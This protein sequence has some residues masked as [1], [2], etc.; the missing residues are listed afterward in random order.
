MTATKLPTVATVD[1][2]L[3]VSTTSKITSRKWKKNTNTLP[4]MDPA[5][6]SLPLQSKIFP[7]LTSQPT[8]L[9]NSRLPSQSNQSQL[10]SKPTHQFSKDTPVVFSTPPL[11]EPA[12]ITP[13]LLLVMEPKKDKITTSSETPG[14]P[15][16][17]SLVTSEW[18]LLKVPVSAVSKRSPST[19]PPTE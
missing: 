11:A 4:E 1:G 12:L 15:H 16:G 17:V 5:N 14:V 19:H 6:T 18:P 13:S 3:M 8:H 10:P 9:P 7:T 2:K